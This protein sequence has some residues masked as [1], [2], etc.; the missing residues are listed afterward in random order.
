MLRCFLPACFHFI[1]SSCISLKQ[2][3]DRANS[4]IYQIHINL[5]RY[6][7]CM[8]PQN[9]KKRKIPYPQKD[10]L[11]A[12][13]PTNLLLHHLLFAVFSKNLF[14]ESGHKIQFVLVWWLV[15]DANLTIPIAIT[16]PDVIRF[17]FGQ[18][19]IEDHYFM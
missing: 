2:V 13:M 4:S 7:I 1:N 9:N 14:C 16:E 6:E 10:S 3:T 8:C 17:G 19:K 5:S 11:A 15:I 18:Q 12:N